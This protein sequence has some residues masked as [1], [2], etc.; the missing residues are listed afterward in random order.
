MHD[1]CECTERDYRQYCKAAL[2]PD[3]FPIERREFHQVIFPVQPVRY[4]KAGEKD[5]EVAGASQPE[6]DTEQLV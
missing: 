3:K 2:Y 5:H 4:L 1:Q 6:G